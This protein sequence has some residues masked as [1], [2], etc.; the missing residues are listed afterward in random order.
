MSKRVA[1][2]I[3]HPDKESYNFAIAQA[4][5]KAAE[6]SGFEIQ[7][8]IIQDLHFNP[9]LQFGYRKRTELEPDLIKSQEILKWANHLVWIYPV[10]WG[11]VPAIMK[12]FLDRILLPGFA[13]SK[14][15]DSLWWD[16][17]F[18]NKTARLI[19]TLDQPSWYY[20]WFYSSPSHKAMKKLTLNFIGVKKV[21]ITTIGPIRLSKEKFRTKWLK[22]VEELGRLAK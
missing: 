19:C 15:K 13:F 7:E 2:I 4:Y 10:W 20:K 5:K 21:R 17:H 8:I 14:K 1:L 18:T 22:K 3:G 12:G 6:I 9:N 16:K 11:S